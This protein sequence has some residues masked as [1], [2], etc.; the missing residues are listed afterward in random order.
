MRSEI[1]KAIEDCSHYGDEVHFKI[2]HDY[3]PA[4]I[5]RLEYLSKLDA[6]NFARYVIVRGNDHKGERIEDV[7]ES[8]KKM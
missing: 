5:D 1:R 3:A 2:M 7:Y 8:Y 6:V 4:L